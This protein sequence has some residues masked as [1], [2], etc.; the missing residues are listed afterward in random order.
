VIASRVLALAVAS[1]SALVALVAL[2][3]IALPAADTL[4]EGRELVLG[5]AVVAAVGIAFCVAMAAS[6][7]AREPAEGAD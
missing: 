4:A 2:A 6:A 1:I 3:R 7:P 5:A